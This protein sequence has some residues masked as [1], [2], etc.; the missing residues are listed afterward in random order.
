MNYLV[1]KLTLDKSKDLVILF[2]QLG[3]ST[4]INLILKDEDVF[5]L[6]DLDSC[7]ML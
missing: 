5:E 6:H 7:Q 2:S 1:S 3:F 4:E